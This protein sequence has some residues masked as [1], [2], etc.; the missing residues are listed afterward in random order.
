M[1][2][3]VASYMMAKRGVQLD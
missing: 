2:S 1:D 3:P